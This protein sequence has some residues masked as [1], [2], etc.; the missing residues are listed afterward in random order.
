MLNRLRHSRITPILWG[1]MACYLLNISIDVTTLFD[2]KVQKNRNYNKQE[3]VVEL[4]FEKILGFE[5]AIPENDSND[6]E[7]NPNTK[8]GFSIDQFVH[9]P[10]TIHTKIIV[11]FPLKKS[12]HYTK[13]KI[14]IPSL[15]IHSPPPEV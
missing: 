7:Q 13:N 15:E 8:K 2:E 4:V 9:T 11:Y 5:E 10:F 6:N 1:F 12:F 14:T 3:S